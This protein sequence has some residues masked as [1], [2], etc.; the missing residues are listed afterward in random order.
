M[1]L[2]VLDEN[3]VKILIE[4]QDIE[5]YDLPFEKINYDDRYSRAFIM[6]LLQK[7]YEETGVNFCECKVMV[8]VIPGVSN[9]YYILLSKIE[10]EG[11]KQIEFDK[12]EPSE[13]DAY[14]FCLKTAEDLIRF[15]KQ[16]YLFYPIKNEVYFYNDSYYVLLNFT[17]QATSKNEF[18]FFL[19]QMEEYGERCK[20][21]I[22]NEA[23]LKEWG[24]LLAG[25]NALER[26]ICGE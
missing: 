1:L 22:I 20:F 11:D 4:D 10:G 17:P 8:E 13:N 21:K 7:T 12:A 26:L 2:K 24:E 23:V 5:L 19:S 3:R 15:L 25:P 9:S 6:E 14:I 18:G 16:I